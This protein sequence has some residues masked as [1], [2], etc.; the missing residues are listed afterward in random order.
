MG[1]QSKGFIFA[2]LLYTAH[3]GVVHLVIHKPLDM[4]AQGLFLLRNVF[5]LKSPV[6]GDWILQ[7]INERLSFQQPAPAAPSNPQIGA[8]TI[9]ARHLAYIGIETDPYNSPFWSLPDL[10]AEDPSVIP[11]Q[12]RDFMTCCSCNGRHIT[13]LMR[14]L[15]LSY[16]NACPFIQCT[17]NKFIPTSFPT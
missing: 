4:P 13:N 1:D 10:W 8:Q 12:K 9:C 11:R 16:I 7:N 6:C 14:C 3:H 2:H 17:N 5:L 15:E